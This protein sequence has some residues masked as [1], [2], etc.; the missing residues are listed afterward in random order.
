MEK[1]QNLPKYLV[2]IIN[3]TSPKIGARGYEIKF[4]GYRIDHEE[5]QEL[6]VS[7]ITGKYQNLT[8]SLEKK[9]RLRLREKE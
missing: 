7:K 9:K 1:C 3:W 4:K 2:N 5:T 6:Q 8:K